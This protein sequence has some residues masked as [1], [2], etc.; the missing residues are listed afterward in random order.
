MLIFPDWLEEAC[1][2]DLEVACLEVH[3]EVVA[4]QMALLVGEEA[5][6][7]VLHLAALVAYLAAFLEQELP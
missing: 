1:L 5:L 2:V 3:E 7:M 6:L 4:H